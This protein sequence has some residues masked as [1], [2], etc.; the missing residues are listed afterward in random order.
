MNQIGFILWVVYKEKIPISYQLV[1]SKETHK[2]LEGVKEKSE[3]EGKFMVLREP[4]EEGAEGEEGGTENKE[5]GI[6]IGGDI[7]FY[8]WDYAS[9]SQQKNPEESR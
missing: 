8:E 3:Q 7:S 2:A 1:Y 5:G 6:T 9:D 4:R